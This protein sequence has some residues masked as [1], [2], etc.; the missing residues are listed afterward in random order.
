MSTV[1]FR[2]I[3]LAGAAGD[4]IGYVVEFD[5]V[6]TIK[7]SYGPHGLRGPL[8]LDGSGEW[9][10]SDDT[11]MTL[12]TI[13]GIFWSR[14]RG[15]ALTK[16]LYRSYMRWY[17]MQTGE[18]PRR[19]QKS[20]LKKQPY[21]TTYNLAKDHRLQ[22]RR[23]PGM[24]CL[25]ALRDPADR[26][27]TQPLN[28]S[29]GCG[30][31]MRVA[32]IGLYF[33]GDPEAAYENGCA[34]AAITHSHPSGYIAAGA[35]A[36]YMALLCDGHTLRQAGK[37]VKE[38]LRVKENADEVYD[39]IVAAEKAAAKVPALR[40][41]AGA[42]DWWY[43][44]PGLEALGE[45]FVAEETLAIAL[46]CALAYSGSRYAVLAALNHGGDSD[47]TAGICAQLVTAEAGRNRIPEEWL[48]HLECR[49]I[50]IDM[51]D[52]LEKI[53]FEEKA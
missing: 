38:M 15:D 44:L 12:F 23:H 51:A 20:W 16:G 34:C 6:E 42:D 3:L 5:D 28:D 4:A 26:S 10:I 31:I 27:M 32:P 45:G 49:D 39:A 11:Q 13:D 48:E 47:S 18:E 2:D 22:E 25:T 35:M 53:S 52:R 1:P 19:G 21:E 7:E 36:S 43:Y 37:V 8:S 9:L 29:K 40:K 17:Y 24:T 50:I 14:Q 33:H 30:G 41:K 46:Y